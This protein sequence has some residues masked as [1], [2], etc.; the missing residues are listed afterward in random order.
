MRFIEKMY[1]YIIALLSAVIVYWFKWGIIDINNFKEILNATI[2]FSS[3]IIAFLSTMV[4]IFISLAGSHVMQR[5]K[6]EDGEGL[7]TSYIAQTVIGGL[8]LVVYSM[9]LLMCLDYNGKYTYLM[10]SAFIFLITFLLS[11]SYRILNLTSK[12]LKNALEESKGSNPEPK[13][14]VAKPTL[15]KND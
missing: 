13:R 15:K 4:S 10:L 3:I 11:S 2:T 12:I 1:P 14:K 8:L 9:V 6:D 5:I 7:L